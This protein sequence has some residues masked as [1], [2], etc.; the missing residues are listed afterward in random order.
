[1]FSIVNKVIHWIIRHTLSLVVI[2]GVL[3]AANFI[4]KEYQAYQSSA[5]VLPTLENAE[6]SINT[7]RRTS[8][9]DIL[10]RLANTKSASVQALN[11]EISSIDQEIKAKKLQQEKNGSLLT[12]LKKFQ[13]VTSI[14]GALENRKYEVEILL[15][16]QARDYLIQLRAYI[17]GKNQLDK[18]QKA[19]TIANE[20]LF[21][22]EQ[23]Q[24]RLKTLHPIATKNPFYYEYQTLKDLEQAH[25]T[26]LSNR[27]VA[28]GNYKQK[29][30]KSAPNPFKM[31]TKRLDQALDPLFKKIAE[32]KERAANNWFVMLTKQVS[33]VI[34]TAV[35]ILLLAILTPIAI[36]AVFYY[37]LAPLAARRPAI[38]ILPNSAGLLDETNFVNPHDAT[39][40]KVSAV[41]LQLNISKNQE[42]LIHP[43]YIQSSS[44][45]GKK[46]TKWFLSNLLPV[47]SLLSGMV[48]LTRIRTDEN[49]SVVISATQD[50]LSEVGLFTI[51]AGSAFVIQPR[52]LIGVLQ[53]KDT[54]MQITRH[55][56]LLSLHAWLTLQLRYLVFH[57]PATLIVKGCRGVRVEKAG[58]GRRISQAATIGFS[59]NL[60]YSTTRCE[61]FF[62]YL[63]SKQELL[64]DGFVGESGYYIY[65]E[66][67]YYGKNEGLASRGLEGFTD[68]LLKVLGI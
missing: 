3:M 18:L 65:E 2:V 68:S 24:S 40:T 48:A 31:D 22:N 29:T 1:M 27:Q 33:E 41:S 8:E 32:E 62:P 45:A 21:K 60:Q 63:T 43:E 46:D 16:V 57:G 25:K 14:N 54:P 26:L 47:S 19:L 5:V 13:T 49:E 12:L 7:H 56:R 15:L 20:Q 23:A 42:L 30:P 36:K 44:I 67:P 53:Q 4:H 50:A 11:V 58:T 35:W 66:M 59:A 52:S 6:Q 38:Q 37:V 28:E 34:A 51:Q 64:F 39:P 61:T 17:D 55:W 10:Q 9:N